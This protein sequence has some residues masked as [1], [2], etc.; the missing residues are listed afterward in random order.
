MAIDIM[1]S[2]LTPEKRKEIM[3]VLQIATPEEGNYDV[4]PICVIE[5]DAMEG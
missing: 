1:L 2:D 4:F 3:D 5:V